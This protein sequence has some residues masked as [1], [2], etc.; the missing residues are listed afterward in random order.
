MSMLSRAALLVMAVGVS[1][2]TVS[3]PLYVAR[4]DAGHPL[5]D[6]RH[7]GG[8]AGNLD[9]ID[10][11]GADLAT[12]PDPGCSKGQ[13][14]CDS[15]GSTVCRNGVFVADRKCPAGSTCH[16]GYCAPPTAPTDITCSDPNGGQSDNVCFLALNA[17]NITCQPYVDSGS[18]SWSC[19]PAVGTAGAG[20]PCMDGKMCRSGFCGSN[21]T[22]FRACNADQDCPNQA[23]N[24]TEVGIAV[25]GQS[26]TAYSCLNN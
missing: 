25:E 19:T 1:A 12:P 18:V 2:C 17:T 22:C 9:P 24:C 4:D 20:T 16:E 21:G 15:V 7:A 8:D 11:G 14:S 3:N 26:I 13:R 23:S 10:L 6:M 5:V